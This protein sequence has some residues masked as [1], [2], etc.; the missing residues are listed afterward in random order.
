MQTQ[1]QTQTATKARAEWLEARRRGIGGSDAAVVLGLS[2]WK[3]PYQLWQEKTGLIADDDKDTPVMY[4]G[5]TLEA[6]I[7]AHYQT[8]TGLYIEVP[9]K[10]LR[11]PENNWMIANVD[12]LTSNGKILEIKTARTADGWG[13]EGTD[14]V[15]DAYALQVQHYMAVTGRKMADIAVL[16]GGSDFRI[17]SIGADVQL[18]SDLIKAESA[19]WELVQ[20]RAPP[21]IIS[22]EEARQRWAH[23]PIKPNAAI[24]DEEI[25]Q[26]WQEYRDNQHL[27]NDL[28]DK[29]E[30]HK[31]AI[32]QWLHNHKATDLIDEEGRKLASCTT[33]KGALRFDG[34]AFLKD[35]PELYKEYQKQG[36]SSV[37]FSIKI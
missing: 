17:Y 14:E 5:R 15:P 13:E 37:R 12:G 10:Q 24:L 33:A 34:K 23:N 21:E 26:V 27:I 29:Q 4:W 20:K 3:T 2:R 35:H 18:Q 31:L 30:R 25:R 19:F 28:Q 6:V 16:I 36:E 9:P 8:A 7:R 22:Y 32:M 1:E 11:H